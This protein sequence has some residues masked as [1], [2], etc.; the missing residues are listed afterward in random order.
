MPHPESGHGPEP[1]QV[2]SP[3]TK[4]I[5]YNITSPVPYNQPRIS[6]TNPWTNS[7]SEQKPL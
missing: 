1:A 6:K 5:L 2:L 3:F 4:P 7:F